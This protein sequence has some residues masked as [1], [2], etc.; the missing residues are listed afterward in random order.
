MVIIEEVKD[1]KYDYI[2]SR[3]SVI[4]GW[5]MVKDYHLLF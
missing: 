2:I 3:F 5:M 4:D 1:I